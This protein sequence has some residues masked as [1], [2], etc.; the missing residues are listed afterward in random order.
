MNRPL[1]VA[2]VDDVDH[3]LRALLHPEG[4]PG[5][6]AV[7]GQHAHAGVADALGHRRDVKVE[8]VSVGEL[9][10]LGGAGLGKTRG[11]GREMI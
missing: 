9:D 3:D 5:D 6:R 8:V 7:V 1:Q 4:R 11:L 10:G 2:L